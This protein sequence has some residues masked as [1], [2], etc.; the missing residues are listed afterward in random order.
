[1]YVCV[2][3]RARASV[4]VGEANPGE[5]PHIFLQSRMKEMLNERLHRVTG[6]AGTDMTSGL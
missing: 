4:S 3:V 2:R 5:M 6:V 1:M